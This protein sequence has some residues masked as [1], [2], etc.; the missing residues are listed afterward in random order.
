MP[1]FPSSVRAPVQ[2][3]SA[4]RRALLS[5]ALAMSAAVCAAPPAPV[6]SGLA[7]IRIYTGPDGLSHFDSGK[8]VLSAVPGG[9]GLAGVMPVNIVGDARNVTFAR[10]AAGATEDWH[11]T[12]YRMVLLCVQGTV[13]VTAADGQKRRLTPG[14]F[15]LA[16]DTSGKG[17]VTHVV[18]AVDHVALAFV[19]PATWPGH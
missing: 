15:L 13:E 17:H 3:R 5:A 18:G 7:Y 1:R 8:L 11:V 12:P 19:P 16:E 10:L 4:S 9:A 2:P 6:S 14:Q